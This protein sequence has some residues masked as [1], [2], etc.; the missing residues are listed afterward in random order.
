M[1]IKKMPSA[2]NWTHVTYAYDDVTYA[3][4]D[5]TYAYDD[6]ASQVPWPQSHLRD[7][8]RPR[9]TLKAVV[10]GVWRRI[11]ELERRRRRQP[12]GRLRRK[13]R[14]Q[15]PILSRRHL[16]YC[17]YYDRFFCYFTL[18]LAT[19]AKGHVGGMV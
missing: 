4:D 1:A 10:H 11:H 9:Q 8:C 16:L 13:P 2:Q 5:V 15:C 18:S 19:P 14:R 6:R 12:Q 17:H 3:Y 7:K